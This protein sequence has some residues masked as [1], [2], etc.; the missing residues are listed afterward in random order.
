MS[1]PNTPPNDQHQSTQQPFEQPQID[2]PQLDQELEEARILLEVSTAVGIEPSLNGQLSCLLELVTRATGADRGTLFVNDPKTQELYSR[3]SAGGLEREI[4]ILNTVGIA[5][6]VF[7]SGEG[8]LVDDAYTDERFNRTVDEQTG[9]RTGA[10]ACAPMRSMQGDMIGVLEVLNKRPGGVFSQRDLRLLEAMGRQASVSLQRSLL[11]EEAEAKRAQETEFLSVVSEMSGELKLGALLQ[12]IISTITRMLKAERSSLFLND[13]KTNELYTEIGEG[14]GATKI[15]FPNHLG[16]AGTV[17]TSGETVNIPY[18]YADLRFNPSFDRQTG[19]FT[20]SMLCTPVVSKAGKLIGVTQVL[21]KR[22]GVFSDADE[23]RLKAFTAQ[24]AVALENA[25][26]FDDVQTMKN[27]AESMLE[28]MSNGVITLGD[29]DVVRTV[30]QAGCRIFQAE[31]PQIIGRAAADL[32]AGRNSWLAERVG[33][34]RQGGEPSVVLDAELEIEGQNCSSNISVLP[35]LSVKG[36]PL[37]SMVMLDDISEEKRMKGTMARYMD[38][39]IAD[40]LMRGGASVLGGAESLATVLFSDIRSFTTLTEALGAQGT[41]QLLNEYFTLMVDCLQKEGGMLDKFIGDAIMAVFGLP[42]A[43][44]Q[45]EDRAVRAGIAMLEELQH[46]NRL[47]GDHG[48]QPITIGIGL[49][50]DTVVSGNIG[51]PKRMNYTVI[52]DGVNLASRLES[53]CKHYGARMLVS[54]DTVQ[55]LRGT[56]RLREADRVVVKGKTQPVLI[57]EVLDFHTAESFPAAM[58]VLNHY[59]DGLVRYRNQ[60]WPGAIAAFERALELHPH[61]RLSQLHLE[62]C[63]HFQAEPPGPDWDGTW[64]M[65]QK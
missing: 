21:N 60:S 59:R 65:Q 54:D 51:S 50:T 57:H 34:V 22:G 26:L 63:H 5:G 11:L 48:L 30:N 20:R 40:E 55:R 25:K 38:P 12:R 47:R 43:G 28:S 3:E 58:E 32:F 15:R 18:A 9:Y 10:I 24:M 29:D 6:H 62:R 37:G 31:A 8:L 39:V 42:V 49:H 61:D 13:D 1:P 14:L 44:E 27:Y 52:G 64:V 35:L 46:F 2:Q 7:Q 4:R 45:D 16:I 19:F 56:Y 23:A 36:Q 33:Q 53:A 41:V 17:F